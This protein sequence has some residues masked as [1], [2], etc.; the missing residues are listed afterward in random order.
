MLKT[1]SFRLY[2]NGAQTKNLS[3]H[4]GA[5]RWVYNRSLE[6]KKAVYAETKKNVSWVELCKDLTVLK[7]TKDTF[8]LRDVATAPL[9]SSIRHLDGAFKR[10]FKEKKGFPVFKSR[11]GRQSFQYPAGVKTDF[12]KKLVYLPRIGWVRYRDPRLFI[13]TVKTVTVVR[14]STGKHY[15]QIL[16]DIPVTP[17]AP[18]LLERSRCLGVDVGLNTFATFSDGRKIANPRFYSS[19]SREIQKAS[20]RLSRKQ[21]GSKNRAKARLKLARVHEKVANRRKDFLHKLT[22]A[23]VSENQVDAWVVETLN[24]KG[25]SRNRS[26]AKSIHDASWSEFLRQLEY[27]SAW[28]GKSVLKIGRFMPSSKTCSCGAVNE[29]LCLADRTWTCN[30]CGVTHDR[31][32]LAAQNI[33]RFADLNTEGNPGIDASGQEPL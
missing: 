14:S 20:R 13:G 25:M 24:V 9:Q 18:K 30:F 2:P 22:T 26:L 12:T 17:K 16:V 33:L 7:K 5:A 1:Y 6:R 23:M 21:K 3:R 8:W 28:R 27:K 19:A 11:R 31:D 4:F 29:D 32:I 10:F 15:A